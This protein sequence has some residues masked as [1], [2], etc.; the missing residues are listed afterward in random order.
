MKSVLAN[1]EVFSIK[2]SSKIKIKVSKNHN[3]L[4]EESNTFD[5]INSEKGCHFD[6]NSSTY[7]TDK[8]LLEDDRSGRGF[9]N[10]GNCFVRF[11]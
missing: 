8:K 10:F 11:F 5:V 6:E 4:Y 9:G 7:K 2:A 3:V 1:K